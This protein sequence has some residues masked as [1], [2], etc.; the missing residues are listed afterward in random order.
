MLKER[1]ADTTKKIRAIDD[2]LAAV[3]GTGKGLTGELDSRRQM[4]AGPQLS[5]GYSDDYNC[6]Q[7]K[8]LPGSNELGSFSTIKDADGCAEEC[9]GVDCASFDACSTDG[10]WLSSGTAAGEDL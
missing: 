9:N 2:K 7:N 10:C 5:D 6:I 4:V 3:A 8:Y 1:E